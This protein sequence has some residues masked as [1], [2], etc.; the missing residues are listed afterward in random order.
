MSSTKKNFLYNSAY[1]LLILLIPLITTPYLSRVL[2]ADGVG[3]YSYYYSI[4]NYFVI[5]ILLGLNNYGNRAIAK[6]R[7]NH[8]ELSK[9]F[10][11]IYCMQFIL[12]IAMNVLFLFYTIFLSSNQLISFTMIL[13]V[14]SG[15]LDINWFFFGIE[16]FKLTV[17]R[18][19]LVKLATTALIFTLVKASSDV[20]LY[21]IILTG[22]MLVSQLVVWPY[23]FKEVVFV[24]PKIKSIFSH[25]KPNIFLFFTVIAVSIYKILDKIMLGSMTTTEQVGYFE[26]AEKLINIP[27]AL[28]V[29]LGTVMLP[30][31][32]NLVANKKSGVEDSLF[33]SIIFA[34]FLSSSLCFGL[35]GVSRE[36]VPLF[37]G[38]NFD[39]VVPLLLVLLPSCVFL[40]FANVIRTQYL[41]PHQMDKVYVVSAFLGAIFNVLVNFLL[42]PKVAALGAAVATIGSE[43]IVCLYQCLTV[44]NKL[45]IFNYLKISVPFVISGIGMFIILFNIV[46]KFSLILS[47]FIKI[48]LGVMIYFLILY[49][50]LIIFYK[51]LYQSILKMMREVI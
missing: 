34:M 13:Y 20:W 22:G 12:G 42:I 11:Q 44:R 21:C 50:L 49:L 31:M 25:I 29:S 27:V 46:L 1:Q 45:P 28:I 36:F 6:V 18:N 16:K 2:G 19:V 39:P 24:K 7:D 15:I 10:W 47:L 33:K 5:F 43:I 17:I 8:I 30:R 35:M 9:T 4:A 23:L 26:S 48:C 38:N 41:L 32:S 40:A 51:S 14:L 37:F 3:I